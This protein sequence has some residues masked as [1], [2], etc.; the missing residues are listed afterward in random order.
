MKVNA[1]TSEWNSILVA[2]ILIFSTFISAYAQQERRDSLSAVTVYADRVRAEAGSRVI[3]PADFRNLPSV[4]GSA[5]AIKFA[6]TLPGVS[7]GAEGSSAIYVRGGNL[8]GNIV[9]IDGVPIYGSSHLLGFSSAYSPDIVS[10]VMFQVGGFTSDEGNLTSSHIS[11]SSVDG[12]M[13]APRVFVSASNFLFG[14]T[15]S[16]PIVKDRLSVVASARLSPIG[17]ELK[18]IKGFSNAMDSISGIKATVYDAYGKLSWRISKRQSAWLSVFNSLDSYGYRYGATSDDRMRWS[19]LI[20]NGTHDFAISPHSKVRSS[21]SYNSFS[22]HQGMQKLLGETTSCVLVQ[23]PLREWILQTT[24]SNTIR[25]GIEFQG[26]IKAR[27]GKFAPGTSS[28]HSGGFGHPQP[29]SKTADATETLILMAHLQTE[30]SKSGKYQLRAAGRLSRYTSHRPSVDSDDRTYINPEASLLARVNIFK[31]FGL[32]ATADWTTQYYHTLEGIPLGWSLD[33][34]VPTDAACGPENAAQYYAGAFLSMGAHRLTLGGYYKDMRNLTYYGDATQLFNSAAASWRHNIKTGTGRSYGM[35]LL[36]EVNAGRFNSRTAYTLSKT[37][38][39]FKGLNENR[40]FP[41]KFDRRHILNLNAEYALVKTKHREVGLSTFFT[42]QSGHHINIAVWEY[43]AELL[44]NGEVKVPV[45]YYSRENA[46]RLPAFIRWDLGC[47][48]RFGIGSTHP[49]TLN[50][51]VYNVLNRHNAYS[52]T[53]DTHDRKW[54]Q[55]S[56]FPIMPSLS[57][58]MEF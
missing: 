18:A 11:V 13:R 1:H 17:A 10:S 23:N 8:G 55:V 49:W 38:R 43:V 25:S 48:M 22:S 7:T 27:S 50:V 19:N 26:G 51:G 32:E 2:V 20:V 52:I 16:V 28:I 54:K 6:Q 29:L 15:V 21:V 44:P 53:Y 42:Y 3:R 14:A 41:A 46:F 47:F 33:M 35:E 58:T 56:L 40:R 5:D 57:W 4:T 31:S 37:D 24:Y 36:Y 30:F 12:D 34:I 9:T 39:L 45:E